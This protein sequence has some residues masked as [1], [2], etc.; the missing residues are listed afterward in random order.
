MDAAMGEGNWVTRAVP[1]YN[2]RTGRVVDVWI[3]RA[4]GNGDSVGDGH[5]RF[6]YADRGTS[7]WQ[8]GDELAFNLDSSE[9]GEG[10]YCVPVGN[11][12]AS[13]ICQHARCNAD[14]KLR[15]IDVT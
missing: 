8:I 2:Y 12:E 1:A 4:D 7:D 10:F 14:N 6:A 11:D 9:C 15:F 3:W 5:G 13:Q